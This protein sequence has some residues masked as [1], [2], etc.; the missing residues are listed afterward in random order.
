ML[1]FLLQ[2][3]MVVSLGFVV[4]LF[5]RVVPRVN[6][7]DVTKAREQSLF[8]WLVGYLE[9][10]DEWLLSLLE[11]TLRRAR[12]VILMLDNVIS[13]KLNRF[14][15]EA[16]RQKGFVIEEKKEEKKEEVSK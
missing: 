2:I 3:T 11:K 10:V 4:Y 5:G 14:K 13:S 9:V 15:K 8:H 12:V 7:A 1:T 6:D 16:E